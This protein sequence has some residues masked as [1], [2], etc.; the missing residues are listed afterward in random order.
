M[1]IAD[2]EWVLLVFVGIIDICAVEL[3][4]WICLSGTW[5]LFDFARI[6]WNCSNEFHFGE[7]EREAD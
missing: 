5:V 6:K 4:N 1:K 7:R 3:R 2:G